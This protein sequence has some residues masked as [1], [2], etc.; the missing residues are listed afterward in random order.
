MVS[1][2]KPSI[3]LQTYGPDNPEHSR[4]DHA[5]TDKHTAQDGGRAYERSFFALRMVSDMR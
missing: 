2:G 3:V 1:V 5:I 4:A